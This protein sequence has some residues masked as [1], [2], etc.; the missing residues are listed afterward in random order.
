MWFFRHFMK[1]ADGS[2]PAPRSEF[3]AVAD[4]REV[5][6]MRLKLVSGVTLL[7]G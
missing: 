5:D 7:V 6:T 2:M 1:G 4:A 3:R